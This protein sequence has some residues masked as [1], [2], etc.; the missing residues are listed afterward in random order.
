MAFH[1]A[2][3]L[4]EG[5]DAADVQAIRDGRLP[6]DAKLASL[7]TLAR[8]MIEKRGQVGVVCGRFNAKNSFGGYVGWR[9]F[10]QVQEH[11]KDSFGTILIEGYNGGEFTRAWAKH[12]LGA[13]F[14]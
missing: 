8:T 1:T 6:K 2:L 7:S 4:K 3:A 9:A 11:K 14:L 12:C 5:I 10:V 13:K